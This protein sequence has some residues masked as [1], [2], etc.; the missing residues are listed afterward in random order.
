MFPKFLFLTEFEGHKSINH[1]QVYKPNNILFSFYF[2]LIF[3]FFKT[4]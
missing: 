3:Y 4:L 1:T 2:L